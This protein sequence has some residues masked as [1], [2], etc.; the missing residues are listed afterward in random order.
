VRTFVFSPRWRYRW[1]ERC[2]HSRS[3]RSEVLRGVSSRKVPHLDLLRF[4][5]FAGPFRLPLDH[6]PATAIK[7][8]AAQLSTGDLARLSH[9]SRSIRSL[10]LP[11][12]YRH[13]TVPF[14][15]YPD[16]ATTQ[17]QLDKR[18]RNNVKRYSR[19]LGSDSSRCRLIRVFNCTN[20]LNWMIGTEANLLVRVLEHTLHVIEFHLVRPHRP[21]PPES[22]ILTEWCSGYG[23][24][25]AGDLRQGASH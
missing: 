10:L 3:S 19:S 7:V 1:Q 8:L 2:R 17:Y 22:A 4:T 23:P 21:Q 25:K 12:L 18:Q 6:L 16:T 13:Y 5:R 20:S 11:L 9:V 15:Y 14:T 24:T